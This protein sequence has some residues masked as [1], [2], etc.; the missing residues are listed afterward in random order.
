MVLPN[1]KHIPVMADKVLEYLITEKDG[2][3]FDATLGDGGYTRSILNELDE[4]GKVVATDRDTEAIEFSKQWAQEYTN[5]LFIHNCNFSEISMVL[6]KE[7]ISQINGVT[8][9]L[10]LSSRQL[11]DENR[12]FSY[13]FDS[14]LDMRMTMDEEITAGR[15]INSYSFEELKSIFKTYGEEKHSGKLAKKILKRREEKDI[16][17]TSEL[18]KIMKGQWHPAHFNKSAAR[19]FQALRI[20][21]NK[22]LESLEKL[23]KDSWAALKPGGRMVI[24][25]YHSLEDRIVKR[26]FKKHTDPC[27]CPVDFPICMCGLVPDAKVLTKKPVMSDA[28]EVIKNS[29]AR[30]A[31]L[32]SAE[33]I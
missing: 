22:E 29:R 10:G 11:D 25:S 19:I 33:K 28:S 12:G 8:A 7:N 1:S 24:V 30:S 21:V 3:Y 9:D 6:S 4:S 27:E 23:L 18:V 17:S 14:P 26:F 20:A 2:I 16:E 5:R 31:K 32:R 13:R 15:I